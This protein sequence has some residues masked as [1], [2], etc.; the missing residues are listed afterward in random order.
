MLWE[1]GLNA[2]PSSY[3]ITY[4]V[5]GKQYVAVVS[6]G[7][8]PLDASGASLAPEF[9]NPAGGTTLWIF[10]LPQAGGPAGQ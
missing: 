7:G 2:T 3:P 10:K 5:D 9:D 8:G 4:S 6:G 1:V